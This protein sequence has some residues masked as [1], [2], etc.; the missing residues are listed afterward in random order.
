MLAEIDENGTLTISPEKALENYALRH[1]LEDWNKKKALLNIA[2]DK[3]TR[4]VLANDSEDT[5]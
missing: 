3:V 1:W 5:E 4:Q 2:V